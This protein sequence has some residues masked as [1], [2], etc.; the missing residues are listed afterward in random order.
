MF[1]E[2]ISEDIPN[3]VNLTL[4]GSSFVSDSSVVE[5]TSNEAEN[6]FLSEETDFNVNNDVK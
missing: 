2:D 4:L 5:N 1:S 3:M 6:K